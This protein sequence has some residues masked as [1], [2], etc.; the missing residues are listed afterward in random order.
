MLYVCLACGR[1]QGRVRFVPFYTVQ[2]EMYTTYVVS[3]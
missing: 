1:V 2:D 3:A